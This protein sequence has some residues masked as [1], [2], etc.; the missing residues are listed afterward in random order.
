MEVKN[1]LRYFLEKRKIVLTPADFARIVERLDADERLRVLNNISLEDLID[2]IPELS[3]R[4]K[5][6]FFTSISLKKS[7]KIISLLP[8][9]ERADILQILPP[10]IRIK[11]IDALDKKIKK[12]TLSLLK[13]EPSSAGG[14][15]T[16]QFIALPKEMK[17]KD[18]IK[19][20]RSRKRKHYIYYVYVVDDNGKLVGV[21]SMRDLL[22]ASSNEKLENIMKRNV[23][24]VLYSAPAREVVRIIKDNNLLAIPVT[25]EE[26][27]LL[28]IVTADDA[29]E[30]MESETAREMDIMA[31]ISPLENVVG[32]RIISL[33]KARL[34]A[35][36]FGFIGTMLMVYV[37]SSFETTL[38]KYLP[39]AF[40]MPL[41][42]YLSDATGTQSE[43]MTIRALALDPK[44]PLSKYI[45]KQF[46]SGIIIS[47]VVAVFCYAIASFIWG[48][49][50]GVIIGLAL[51]ISMN[52]SNLT[53]S[54]LPIIYKR[55]L[56]V[57]PAGI[58]G[59]LDT[60]LSDISTLMIYFLV[61]SLL[62]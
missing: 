21:A 54:L 62:I 7:A 6:L 13:Y 19:T 42:V 16:T 4:T 60:I 31:G 1:V 22:L 30:A 12:E 49:K 44:L 39:L 41:L 23:I 15:M 5:Y 34:P 18:V 3:N 50:F 48:V 40:F 51:F 61:A 24:R 32:A 29:M 28:G 53:A 57:D 14:L 9:D 33:A 52:F 47:S 38:Q 43:S 56:K 25:D 55:V 37:V 10:N 8:P 59:P 2:I 58:S 46:K 45:L 27:R 35:L 17:V 20:I 36:L 11:I 26:G